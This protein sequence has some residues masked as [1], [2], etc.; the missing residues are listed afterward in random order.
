MERGSLAD[1]GRPDLTLCLALIH[2]LAISA[3]VPVR[4]IVEWLRSLGGALVIEFVTKEDPMVRRLLQNKRDDY[5]DYDRAWFEGCL[6]D[7]FDVVEVA[8]LAGGTRIMY[9]ATPR[10]ST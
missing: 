4:E 9:F 2:H 6:R 7:L 3:N 5:A 1:R 10:G 8:E